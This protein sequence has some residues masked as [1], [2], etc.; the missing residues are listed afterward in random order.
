VRPEHVDLRRAPVFGWGPD[1][2]RGDARLPQRLGAQQRRVEE[3]TAH[4]AENA[5]GRVLGRGHRPGTRAREHRLH[6]L[7][8]A[9]LRRESRDGIH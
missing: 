7:L 8:A 6:D 2:H 3:V 5:L 4:G 1:G 9:P